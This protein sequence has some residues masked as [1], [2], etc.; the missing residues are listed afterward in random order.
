M[1][2]QEIWS[3]TARKGSE[4][5]NIGR[6]QVLQPELKFN[7]GTINWIDTGIRRTERYER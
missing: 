5:V 6:S 4:V 7:G 3:A 2:K 1:N